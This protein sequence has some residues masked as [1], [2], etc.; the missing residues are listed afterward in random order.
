MHP[1]T[2]TEQFNDFLERHEL[3]HI[4]F[5]ALRHTSATLSLLNGANIKQVATRLGHSQLST[6]NRYLHAIQEA[7]RTIADS[8]GNTI[9]SLKQK[10]A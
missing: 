8:L 10:R 3:K 7:D 6:T 4:K 1:N 2:P 9:T 5:H